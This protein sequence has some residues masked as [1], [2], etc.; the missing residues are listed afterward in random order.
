M[1]GEADTGADAIALGTGN[2]GW[3]K[4]RKGEKYFI[5]KVQDKR[6]AWE[7]GEKENFPEEKWQQDQKKPGDVGRAPEKNARTKAGGDHEP[8]K[9]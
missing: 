1:F 4:S 6:G 2:D 3:G 9:H 7:R 8:L 5:Y